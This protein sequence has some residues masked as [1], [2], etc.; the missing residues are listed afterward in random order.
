M[1]QNARSFKDV[2]GRLEQIVDEVNAEGVTLD[3]ALK[4][5]EEAVKLGLSACEL[6]ESDLLPEEMQPEEAQLESAET[7]PPQPDPT[8][9]AAY[10]ASDIAEAALIEQVGDVA[11]V[12]RPEA[13]DQVAPVEAE[14]D[15]S[16]PYSR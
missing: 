11:S 15:G 2:R 5:Y 16:A 13:P 1:E 6:S 3:E 8:V 7:R 14:G 12:Q 4:L 9:A 10:E